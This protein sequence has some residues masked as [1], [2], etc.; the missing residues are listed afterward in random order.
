MP[1]IFAVIAM[2]WKQFLFFSLNAE[3]QLVETVIP[4]YLK[5][6]SVMYNYKKYFSIQIV[7]TQCQL[8]KQKPRLY[9][10][11]W[12]A[13]DIFFGDTWKEEQEMALAFPLPRILLWC[14]R[15]FAK[16]ISRIVDIDCSC[17]EQTEL[18]CTVICELRL[19]LSR[20]AFPLRL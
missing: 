16:N 12:F 19:E 10:Q 5:D 17:V 18:Y 3:N 20:N 9:W 13:N 4:S 15:Q 14:F 1:I 8:V 6:M 11:R 2:H 7:I